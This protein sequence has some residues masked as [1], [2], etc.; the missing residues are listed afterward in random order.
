MAK[1][2][3]GVRK[4]H[5][6]LKRDQA[7]IAR[8]RQPEWDV[9]EFATIVSEGSKNKLIVAAAIKAAVSIVYSYDSQSYN[10]R[11]KK[12]DKQPA[13]IASNADRDR[14]LIELLKMI[15]RENLSGNHAP[16]PDDYTDAVS[17]YPE[18]GLQLHLVS[19]AIAEFGREPPLPK[20]NPAYTSARGARRKLIPEPAPI[21]MQNDINSDAFAAEVVAEF[22]KRKPNA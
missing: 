12:L 10:E 17:E 9:L 15:F 1:A 3:S 5:A 19:A 13:T 22:N 16:S 14:L 21:P 4:G 11:C 6:S 8:F 18:L 2:D 7:Y 20:I